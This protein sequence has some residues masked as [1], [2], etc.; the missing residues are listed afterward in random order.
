MEKIKSIEGSIDER[1]RDY[2]EHGKRTN[3]KEFQNYR[4]D[5]MTDEERKL[6]EDIIR[7]FKKSYDAK[8]SAGVYK[9]MEIAEAYWSGEFANPIGTNTNII[10]SN[11]ETQVADL[12]DQNIDVELKPYDPSDAPWITRVRRVADKILDVNKMPLKIKKLVRS[13]KKFGNGWLRVMFNP[14]LLDGMGCP[15]ITWVSSANVLPDASI[16]KIEDIDKGRYFIEFFPAPIYWAEQTFGMEKASAIYPNYKPYSQ[17][18]DLG[19]QDV[20]DT[21][22]ENYLH[23][24]YWCKYKDKSGK[25]K[26]RLIQCSG[27]GI[28]LKDSANFEEKRDVDVFPK[29]E[30]VQYPYFCVNDMERENSIWGKTNASLLYPIQDQIDELDN[31]ILAN[32]RL[33]GNPMKEVLSASGVDPEKIDNSEGQVFVSNVKNGVSYINPP[34]MPSYIVERRN[35]AL[36]MERGIVSR[37]SDQQSGI[38]DHGVDTATESL[39]IQQNAMKATD[40]AKV[41]LQLMLSDVIMYCINLAIEFWDEDMYFETEENGQFDYFNPH[42]LSKIPMLKPADEKYIN[43]FKKANPNAELP[44][45]MEVKDKYRRIHVLLSVSVGAGLPKNKALMYNVIKETYMNKAMGV[46]EYREKL[47][48]YFGLPMPNEEDIEGGTSNMNVNIPYVN[49]GNVLGGAVNPN[50][51]TKMNE[52]HGGGYNVTK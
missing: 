22:G 27:C 2:F 30:N 46:K 13:V 16:F 50:T 44:E 11:I 6:G 12:M 4:L 15:E 45:Y 39:A 7:D 20:V 33:T 42:T 8:A 34:S 49:E 19:V 5:K 38:K 35:L 40:V 26:L 29:L 51:L 14:E 41:T 32:A 9:D 31:Q 23:I 3:A 52:Q 17:L 43:A 1:R 18:L 21:S 10:N 24:L 47:E 28:I 48:E 25:E 37:V 36:T